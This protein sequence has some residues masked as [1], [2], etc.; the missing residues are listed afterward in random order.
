MKTLLIAFMLICEQQLF[1]Q[2]T[3]DLAVQCLQDTN[4][5]IAKTHANYNIYTRKQGKGFVIISL[6]SNKIIGFSANSLWNE[7]TLP[8][9]ITYWITQLGEER[10]EGCHMQSRANHAQSEKKLDQENIPPLLTTHWHQAAPYN[11]MCP[12]IEDGKIK[13][14]AGCV[15][16][17]AAQI[18]YY[19]RKDNPDCLLEDTP[20][21]PYGQAPVTISIAKGMPNN[22]N[23]IAD[24]YTNNTDKDSQE[25][26]AQLVYAIGTTSYLNY[27]TSTG[28]QIKNAG[29]ALYAL[30]Q[31]KSDYKAQKNEN[32]QNWLSIIYENL[33]K[34]Y[35]VLYAGS[36]I[37]NDGHA[38]VIDGYD[39]STQLYHI[40]FGWGGDGDGYYLISEQDGLSGYFNNQ[41]CVYNLR[42]TKRNL[43]IT[44]DLQYDKTD[45]YYKIKY[46]IKNNSTLPITKTYIKGCYKNN[47][48]VN[49]DSLEQEIPVSNN[50]YDISYT[51]PNTNIENLEK[52]ILTDENGEYLR[53]T[54]PTLTS[55]K[56][57]LFDNHSKTYLYNL[58]GIAVKTNKKKGIIIKKEKNKTFKVF[59]K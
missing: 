32:I 46:S 53:E 19:W 33:R 50:F 58:N 28:G 39:S 14:A 51:I 56:N 43:S 21:Y 34:G 29:N 54:S 17:A 15:A 24:E 35:P 18:A 48:I 25:A 42:P 57:Q 12:I 59:M 16:I 2:T 27:G 37:N 52:I 41:S 20:T 40:N 44:E 47:Y 4:I 7:K 9:S 10:K 22:W 5:Y 1:A 30:F 55:I 45:D 31:L 3:H 23:L 26:V 13:T 11:N 8:P 36:T 38:F 49:L 6:P